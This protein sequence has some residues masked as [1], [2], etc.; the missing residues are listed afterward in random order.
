MDINIQK[1]NKYVFIGG[2]I[3]PKCKTIFDSATD[4]TLT[5]TVFTI[6]EYFNHDNLKSQSTTDMC[7][8][9]CGCAYNKPIIN[10]YFKYIQYFDKD[11]NLML[12]K[13]VLELKEKDKQRYIDIINKYVED[14]KIKFE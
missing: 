11:C 13:F 5:L 1:N 3:C 2:Y 8:L 4:K 14:N 10:F 7:E 9:K 6:N 12:P